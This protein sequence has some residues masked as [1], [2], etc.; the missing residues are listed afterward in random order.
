MMTTVVRIFALAACALGFA[1]CTYLTPY[2]MEI[3]QGSVLTQE[4]VGKLKTGMTRSQVAYVMGT[5]LLTDAFHADRWDY[6][7]YL[8][9]RER[10]VDQRKVVLM[11]DGDILKDIRSDVPPDKAA[12]DAPAG[13]AAPAE[14][15][16]PA[17]AATPA[18]NPA[19]TA[20]AEAPPAAPAQPQPADSV[21]ANV[22]PDAVPDVTKP[23]VT[24]A[25]E[26]LEVPTPSTPPPQSGTR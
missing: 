15:A 11:F 3:Q 5:P 8:R 4:N 25:P 22:V 26:A 12:K 18:A 23:I 19:A 6:V 9:K 13:T 16:K 20:P 14:A 10:I 7:Y 21:P 17:A 24:P 2:K 1:A